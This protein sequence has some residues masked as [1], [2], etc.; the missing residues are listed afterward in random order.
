MS[1][2]D[3]VFSGSLKKGFKLN[4]MYRSKSAIWILLFIRFVSAVQF[5]F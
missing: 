3:T 2:S 4:L 5:I 1:R